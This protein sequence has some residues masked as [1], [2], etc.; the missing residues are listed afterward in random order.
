[1]KKK[2]K[3]KKEINYS[4]AITMDLSLRR[5]NSRVRPSLLATASYSNGT[6]DK[7]PT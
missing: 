7:T 4:V 2:K 6:L 1:M 3:R 5:L